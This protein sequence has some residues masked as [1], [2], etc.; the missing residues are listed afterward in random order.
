MYSIW[1]WLRSYTVRKKKIL[2]RVCF[3]DEASGEYTGREVWQKLHK[4]G[5]I[6]HVA[7][8]EAP[9]SV[10]DATATCEWVQSYAP[11]TRGE[12]PPSI[13]SG[14]LGWW[15]LSRMPPPPLR[16]RPPPPPPSRRRWPRWRPST[17]PGP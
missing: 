2:L 3:I 17:P 11:M 14:G 12:G 1:G 7:G 8:Y 9:K 15:S 4:G 10:C 5:D 6:N 16:V 13:Q